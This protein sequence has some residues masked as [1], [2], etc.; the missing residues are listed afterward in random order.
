VTYLPFFPDDPEQDRLARI[1]W[2]VR[3]ELFRLTIYSRAH[4]REWEDDE[5]ERLR[6]KSNEDRLREFDRE[7]RLLILWEKSP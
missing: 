2:D 4:E 3:R 5:H 7:T 6:E 1:I